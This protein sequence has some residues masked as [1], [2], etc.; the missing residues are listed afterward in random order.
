[1]RPSL[2]NRVRATSAIILTSLLLVVGTSCTSFDDRTGSSGGA[3]GPTV[4]ATGTWVGTWAVTT[5]I[6]DAGEVRFVIDQDPDDSVF[7]TT[8]WSGSPC[9][10]LP[11]LQ[12]AQPPVT[13][14]DDAEDMRFTGNLVDNLIPAAT[15]VDIPADPPGSTPRRVAYRASAR[16]EIIGDRMVGTFEVT[17]PG[18]SPT[19]FTAATGFGTSRCNDLIHRVGDLGVLELTR[20]E[21]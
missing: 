1:M 19:D 2:L 15:V 10:S 11:G 4:V 12:V 5:G 9:W 21:E 3:E 17:T 20:V 8:R 18:S 14:L 13:S 6:P 16:L 7:G